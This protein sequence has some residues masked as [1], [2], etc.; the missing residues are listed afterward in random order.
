MVSMSSSVSSLCL[1]ANTCVAPLSNHFVAFHPSPVYSAD[2]SAGPV[3][4]QITAHH[5][6]LHTSIRLAQR[7]FLISQVLNTIGSVNDTND[8]FLN[9]QLVVNAPNF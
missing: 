9:C 5:F 1:E 3:R 4:A 7:L 8:Q 6:C 2:Q